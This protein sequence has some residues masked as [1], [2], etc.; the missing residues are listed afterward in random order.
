[1]LIHVLKGNPRYLKL[2]IHFD[3]F[4]FE[5][6][7]LFNKATDKILLELEKKGKIFTDEEN[8]KCINLEG[9]NLSMENPYLPLTRNDNTSLYLLR[10]IAYTLYKISRAKERN[11][12]ILGEDQKLYF[13]QLKAILSILSYTAPEVIHYSFVLLPSGK[14]STRKGEVV[15]LEDFMKELFRKIRRGNTEEG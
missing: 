7:F 12:L 2:D 4:D 13:Q 9:F 3:H 14:M 6:D 11:I 8:R 5:S 10:D 15:L 1:M